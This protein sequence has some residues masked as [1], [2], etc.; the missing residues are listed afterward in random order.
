VD[1]EDPVEQVRL[2]ATVSGWVQGVGFRWATMTHA[3]TLQLVGVAQN[4]PDGDVLV[5]AEGARAQCQLLLD[6]LQ[7]TG[8]QTSFPPGRVD[9]VEVRW[10]PGQGR[11]WSFTCR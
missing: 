11:F 7:G 2:T 9:F 8:S 3:Q 4:L 10:G 5:I 6:W 1:S